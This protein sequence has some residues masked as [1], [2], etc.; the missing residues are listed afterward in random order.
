VI[1][2]AATTTRAP[3]GAVRPPPCRAL[4]R[5]DLVGEL[6]FLAHH[7][8]LRMLQRALVRAGWPLAFSQGFNPRPRLTV[9]LPRNLGCAARG[10]LA[11]VALWSPPPGDELFCRLAAELPRNCR[12]RAVVVPLATGTPHPCAAAYDLEL[13]EDDLHGIGNRIRAL[14]DSATAVVPR[15][16]GPGKPD[17]PFDIRP[18][19]DKLE[20]RG[21]TLWMEL[22]FVQQ[23]TT[24]PAEV[25]TALGLSPDTYSTAVRRVTVRWDIEPVGPSFGPAG[26]TRNA[27]DDQED[28]EEAIENCPSCDDRP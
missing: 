16:C 13:E 2:A 11:L 21:A 12:L 19:I 1:S 26:D 14:L 18:Y 25:I 28:P 4:L 8:E 20:L 5:Y 3:G 9:P 6:R 24:R 15:D 7:D 23:R 27:L 22:R 10:Q 17:R